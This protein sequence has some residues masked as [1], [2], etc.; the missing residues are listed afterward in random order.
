M[1]WKKGAAVKMPMKPR[2]TAESMKF[3]HVNQLLICQHFKSSFKFP[4]EHSIFHHS[5]P[6]VVI[7]FITR[8]T[9]FTLAERDWDSA[10]EMKNIFLFSKIS[11]IYHGVTHLFTSSDVNSQFIGK[12]PHAGKDWGQKE[13]RESENEMAGWHHQC[14][15]REPGQTL[16]DGERQGSMA[17]C[18]PWGRKESDQTGRLNNISLFNR[19]KIL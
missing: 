9:V 16:G 14:N 6:V 17:C 12:V 11:W 5:V 18:S 15:G 2:Y 3:K 8:F 1:S 13:K 19:H 4:T 7:Q 10:M